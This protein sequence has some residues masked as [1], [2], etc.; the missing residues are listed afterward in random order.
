M[1]KESRQEGAPL[2]KKVTVEHL[3]E[4]L[5]CSDRG[6]NGYSCFMHHG[7][8]VLEGHGRY[9]VTSVSD[10]GVTGNGILGASII[11]VFSNTAEPDF[12]LVI[13]RHTW[14]ISSLLKTAVISSG[15]LVVCLIRFASELQLNTVHR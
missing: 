14:W 6:A 3:T 15:L 5:G 1:C 2:I 12:G 10:D 13:S 8:K 4:I 7:D 11:S 9:I